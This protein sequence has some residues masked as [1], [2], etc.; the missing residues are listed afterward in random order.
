[1]KINDLP[2]AD[3]VAAARGFLLVYRDSTAP[4]P[5][6]AIDDR[7][8]EPSPTEPKTTLWLSGVHVGL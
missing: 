7:L 4:V 3:H 2:S 6:A 5:F 1:M 8:I